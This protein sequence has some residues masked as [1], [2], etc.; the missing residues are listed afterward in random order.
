MSGIHWESRDEAKLCVHN[1]QPRRLKKPRWW[2]R[3]I[4]SNRE[5]L[6]M[7]EWLKENEPIRKSSRRAACQAEHFVCMALALIAIQPIPMTPIPISHKQALKWPF[8]GHSHDHGTRRGRGPKN[9][10]VRGL[11]RT[12][13]SLLSLRL[14]FIYLESTLRFGP[15]MALWHSLG[16][17]NG[18]LSET[19]NLCMGILRSSLNSP[20]VLEYVRETNDA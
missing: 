17:V 16:Q 4:G 13:R 12:L 9:L 10:F 15:C 11:R 6:C 3:K 5:S 1:S 2:E 14:N 19:L 18:L 20:W 8:P 7:A